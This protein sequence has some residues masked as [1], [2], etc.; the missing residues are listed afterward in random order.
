MAVVDHKQGFAGPLEARVPKR[1]LD[2]SPAT[3]EA[4][5]RPCDGEDVVWDVDQLGE[6]D[7]VGPRRQRDPTLLVEGLRTPA[8]L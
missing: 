6:G 2:G 1:R 8:G 5:A 7:P 3:L 4:R